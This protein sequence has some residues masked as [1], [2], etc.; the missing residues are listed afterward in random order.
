MKRSVLMPLFSSFEFVFVSQFRSNPILHGRKNSPSIS[1]PVQ[2]TRQNDSTSISFGFSPLQ[3][4]VN[5][6]RRISGVI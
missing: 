1:S 3:L 4:V 6:S 2:Q 5:S